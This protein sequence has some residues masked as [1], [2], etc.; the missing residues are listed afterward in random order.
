MKTFTI[1]L[2]TLI[3]SANDNLLRCDYFYAEKWYENPLGFDPIALHTRNGFL[4]PALAVGLCLWLTPRDSV[5]DKTVFHCMSGVSYGYKHP[6]TTL[7]QINSGFDYFFRSWLSVGSEISFFFPR[8]AYNNTFGI[9]IFPYA[10]F[11]PLNKEDYRLFFECGGGLV[12]FFNQFPLPNDKDNRLGTN[13]NGT[14]RY[15]IGSEINLSRSSSIIF[16]IRHVH[17]SNGNSVGVARNP[18]HD[19]NGFYLGLSIN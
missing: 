10:R 2:L 16:G 7:F 17:I 12:Y 9:A 5:A 6:E 19:S 13:L 3:L 8:D 14:T 11:Y 15:G 1:I 4:L 18:S